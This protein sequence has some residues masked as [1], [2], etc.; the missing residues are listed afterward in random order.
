MI[1]CT[2]SI[3]L[4]TTRTPF[5]TIEK[6]LG[7]AG[8]FF[9]YCSSFF[10]PTKLVGVVGHDFPENYR[11]LLE[12]KGIDLSGVKVQGKTMFVDWNYDYELYSRKTNVLELN[13]LADFKPDVPKEWRKNPFVYLGT[14]PPEQQMAVLKQMESPKFTLLDTIDF[15]IQTKKSEI[16]RAFSNANA[17]LINEAEARLFARTPNLFKAARTIQDLGPSVVI[18]KKGEHGALLFAEGTVTP[19]PAYPME[20]VIDPTGAGDSFA[21]GFLGHIARSG[22]VKLDTLK[23]AMA[24]G[25]VMGSF[26]VED[27][28]MHR[29]LKVE[30]QDIA[31]RFEAYKRLVTLK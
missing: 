9:S 17:V 3:A 4:D 31:D 21:G 18:I 13:A 23:T 24:F 30:K 16:T 1:L 7:G 20:E 25:H 19:S 27:F 29:L 28:G 22:N 8:S 6:A 10:A 2:G 12:N 26:A 14:V 15:Y 5:R 11:K